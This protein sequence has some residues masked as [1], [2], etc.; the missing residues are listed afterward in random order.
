MEDEQSSHFKQTS[1]LTPST[2]APKRSSTNKKQRHER[3]P[4]LRNLHPKDPTKVPHRYHKR[5]NR[6]VKSGQTLTT[7]DKD[8]NNVAN[9]LPPEDADK[10]DDIGTDINDPPTDPTAPSAELQQQFLKTHD[11]HIAKQPDSFVYLRD[12]GRM[13]I[14]SG[15]NLK[16]L[17]KTEMAM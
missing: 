8:D 13:K 2:T 4:K 17:F 3:V 16:L 15:K 14:L 11:T 9:N 6:T 10:E 12:K 7:S 5:G 1:S